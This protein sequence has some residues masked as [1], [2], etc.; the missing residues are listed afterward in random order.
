MNFSQK[1]DLQ[2]YQSLQSETIRQDRSVPILGKTMI[3]PVLP[4]MVALGIGIG[5]TSYSLMLDK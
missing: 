4:M 1:G 2:T 5:V 3:L